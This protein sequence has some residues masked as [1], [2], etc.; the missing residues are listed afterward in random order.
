MI[1]TTLNRTDISILYHAFQSFGFSPFRP[2]DLLV[3]RGKHRLRVP[4][5][6][7]ARLSERARQTL[8]LA[9]TLPA[10]DPYLRQHNTG[11]YSFLR[12]LE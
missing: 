10:G 12:V 3:L 6:H 1:R 4:N 5:V 8:E 2:I 9:L 11:H 7:G